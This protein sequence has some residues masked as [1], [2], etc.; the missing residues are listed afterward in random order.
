MKKSGGK[1]SILVVEDEPIVA[2]DL[3]QILREQGY[4]A[5]AI[6]SSADDAIKRAAERCPDL[7]LMDIRIKG[8]LDGIQ[9]AEILR[10]RFGVAVIYLTA[11]ADEATIERAA[12]SEPYGYLLKP[13][14]VAELRSAVEIAVYKQ[15]LDKNIRERERWFSTALQSVRDAV[16]A[17]DAAGKVT[18][19]NAAAEELLGAQASAVSGKQA[20]EVLKILNR[21]S[22]VA[23]T[24]TLPGETE[25]PSP[26][27]FR[28]GSKVMVLHDVGEKKKLERQL[29]LADR[30]SSLGAMAASTAH[31]LNNPLTVVMTN[32]GILSEEMQ[33]LRKSVELEDPE[34]A[35]SRLSRMNE[36]ISD[37]QAAA[38]RMA[39][40]VSNLRAFAR[41]ADNGPERVDLRHCVEWAVRATAHEFQ[42]RAHIRTHFEPAPF[43]MGEPARIEQ[44]LVN[45]LV[46]AAQAI[47]P[48]S[49]EENEVD[50]VLRTAE[51]GRALIEVRDTGG[52]IPE[53][54][55]GKI[56][57][58][59]FT[60][61][62]PGIGTGLGLS[63]C[64]GIM[65]AL[66][67]EIRVA[68]QL[69]I[70]TTFTVLMDPAPDMQLEVARVPEPAPPESP[71]GRILVIDDEA[72]LLR[73]IKHIL[74]DDGHK[75]VC[76]ERATDAL[77]LLDQGEI[78]DLIISDIMMPAMTGMELYAQLQANHPMMAPRM[79][80]ITGGAIT[81]GAAAFLEAV[82]NPRLEKPFKIAQL[83]T[84]VRK[85]LVAVF[86]GEQPA[87]SGKHVH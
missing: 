37:L 55:L 53:H 59:F 38:S 82:P 18:F 11:H 41:P 51:D 42:H 36:S 44:V 84:A 35:K 48:G 87:D 60:T 22:I 61:K 83:C 33:A 5:F 74:E 77:A 54:A 13:I 26:A 1:C 14:K 43:V 8:K 9:T 20:S 19:V 25:T 7:V 21:D 15:S 86:S 4:D 10:R 62:A 17:S 47:P 12:R 56:F 23:Q 65:Q 73:A 46:N 78:F 45:L 2:K 32:S 80:F 57:D 3:Q 39:R 85:A 40:I 81:R 27:G 6:A 29:E 28:P 72:T 66:G 69:G 49:V 71:S 30:L 63:I 34:S 52:G 64:Q 68:S 70:G 79:L 75:V 67:G 58:P 31:E 24:T 50:V 16:I 76:R